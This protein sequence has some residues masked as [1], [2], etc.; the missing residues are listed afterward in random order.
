MK[1]L[2][3]LKFIENNGEQSSLFEYQANDSLLIIFFRGAWCNYCKKQLK[4]FNQKIEE[5]KALNIK[6][7]A[8]SNDSKLNSS[9]LRSFLKLEFPVIADPDLEIINEFNLKTEYKDKPVSKP[10]IYMYN[11]EYEEVFSYIGEEYDDRLSA[12][13]I[14]K[15]INETKS[16]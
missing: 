8:I 5:F 10:A 12:E 6:I 16:I 7:L 13:E 4:E 15:Q 9:L 3:D 1:N 11:P 2:K 14:L